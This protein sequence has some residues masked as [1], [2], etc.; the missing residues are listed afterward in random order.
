MKFENHDQAIGWQDLFVWA[1]VNVD[2][3]N[4]VISRACPT[5]WIA[6]QRKAVEGESASLSIPAPQGFAISIGGTFP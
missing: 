1:R 5:L 3:L 4:H 6:M 2:G